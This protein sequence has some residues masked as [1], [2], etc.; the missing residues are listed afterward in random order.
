MS[1]ELKLPSYL[2]EIEDY[3]NNEETHKYRYSTDEASC[4]INTFILSDE[5]SRIP[6]EKEVLIQGLHETMDQFRGIIE[7]ANG[8]TRSGKEYVYYI[9]KTLVGDQKQHH[10]YYLVLQ[11]DQGISLTQV[12]G[13]FLYRHSQ[14]YRDQ[15]IYAK[16]K[17]LF[18]REEW[19]KDPYDK[20]FRRGLL[21]NQGEREEYDILF[22]EHPLTQARKLV[23]D[24]IEKN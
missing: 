12:T 17:E 9:V 24:L 14:D 8:F 6:R 4:F 23:K 19:E 3:D 1:E 13:T 16:F 20:N 15:E 7:V 18:P 21:M 2:V 11:L 10:C 22:P 5:A